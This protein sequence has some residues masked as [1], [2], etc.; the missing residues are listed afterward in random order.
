MIIMIHVVMKAMAAKVKHLLCFKSNFQEIIVNKYLQFYQYSRAAGL[1]NCRA[2]LPK[3]SKLYSR[4]V[5]F[6][7]GVKRHSC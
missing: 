6:A 3:D 4:S 2:I 5:T 1:Q 7:V